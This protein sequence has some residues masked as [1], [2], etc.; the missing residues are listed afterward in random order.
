MQRRSFVAGTLTTAFWLTARRAG[1][2]G[3]LEGPPSAGVPLTPAVL[4]VLLGSGQA[5]RLDARSFLYNGRPYRGSFSLTQINSRQAV[6]NTLPLEEYLYSVVPLESPA[7]WPA[8]TLQSQAIVARTFALRR[9]NQNRPYDVL[10][11]ERDQSYGGIAAELPASTAAVNQ[12]LGVVVHFNN[13]LASV[14]YMSCCGG[15]TEDA[16]NIWGAGVPYLRGGTD[17]Y[18]TASPDYRW[19]HEIPWANF[20]TAFGNR[21]EPLGNVQSINVAEIDSSGRAKSI[22]LGGTSGSIDIPGVEFRRSLGSDVV[23]S[24]LI[25]TINLNVLSSD[26]LDAPAAQPATVTVAGAGR[27]HGVGLCQWGAYG[28]G[29][30]GHSVRDMLSFYFPGTDVGP[31]YP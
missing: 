12:T 10:G 20:L 30:A 6:I 9:M 23:R 13:A 31:A 21:L 29:R 1:A 2:T 25:R 18:C 11:S 16:A 15:R 17:P 28:M 8:V 27:G 19:T 24:L 7:S 4:R 22:S 14:S 5:T 3:G 26:Q